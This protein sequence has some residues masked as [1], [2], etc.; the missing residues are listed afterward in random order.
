[1]ARLTAAVFAL[2]GLTAL[3]AAGAEGSLFG[4]LPRSTTDRPDDFPGLQVHMVYVVPSDR[5]D[6]A[7]DTDGSIQNGVESF[8][9]W[10]S[11]QTGGRTYRIDTFQGLAD[12]TFRRLPMPDPQ[13]PF[14]AVMSDLKAIG[15][16]V[17]GKVY[18]V[19][20]DG[21]PTQQTCGGAGWPQWPEPA[22]DG[23]IAVIYL[24]GLGGA[25]YH[26]F[27]P[28]GG[29]PNYTVFSM[30]HDVTHTFGIVGRCAP[31]HYAVSPAHVNDSNTDLMWAGQGFWSPSVLDY[32]RDD[33][34]KAPVPG[35]V[36]LDT[37]GFLSQPTNSVLSVEKSGNGPGKVES[38]PWPLISC[39]T[40]C[41]APYP[42]GAEIALD[43]KPDDDSTF[44]GWGGACTGQ[45][46][47]CLVTLD[48][49]KAVT[50]RFHAPDRVVDVTLSGS[51]RGTVTSTPPSIRCPTACHRTFANGTA[52]SIRAK[53]GRGSQFA[54]WG[55]DC[56]GKAAACAFT[57]TE[58]RYVE[59]RF[60]DIQAPQVFALASRG[61]RGGTAR[62]RYRVVENTG[63]AR[64]LVSVRGFRG[65]RRTAF[66]RVTRKRT[67]A[68][69]WRVPR[70][71]RARLR[72][73]VRAFDR[74]RHASRR[75]C[76][77]LSV[78]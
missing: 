38:T 23:T 33:Y 66:R 45:A 73:C 41:S 29:E 67:Y 55:S 47:R 19:Y 64:V 69:A 1:M 60:V 46:T 16:I 53:A 7:F 10:V 63:T 70:T 54:G 42:T 14:V 44:E 5:L 71:A 21:G 26:G 74:A 32:G 56:T 77:L 36:D 43:A 15:L 28:P 2:A 11:A 59:A 40:T 35:C 8:Q 18:G 27:P 24:G 25:C 13:Y 48:S 68:V 17:P 30:F 78:R 75:S 39:G 57:V 61:T 4:S 72:F 65:V 37:V 34:F 58:D 52:V 22:G 76:A 20:Y 50:A 6:R 31:H 49:S 62:L 51:G 12:V 9:R 3:F